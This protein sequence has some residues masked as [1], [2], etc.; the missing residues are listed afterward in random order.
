MK[1]LRRLMSQIDS[2]EE[3]QATPAVAGKAVLFKKLAPEALPGLG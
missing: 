2:I 1:P 3:Q